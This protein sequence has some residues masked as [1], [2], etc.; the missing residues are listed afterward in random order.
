MR[1]LKTRLFLALWL[2][3]SS[4][5]TV[6]MYVTQNRLGADI[7][8]AT[9]AADQFLYGALWLIFTPLILWIAK[10]IPFRKKGWP[11]A[12]GL[13]FLLGII[14]AVAQAWLYMFILSLYGFLASGAPLAFDTLFTRLATFFDYGIHLYWLVVVLDYVYEYYFIARRHELD[15]AKLE[16]QLAGAHLR[17]LTMQVRPHFLFN[18]LNSI[19]VLIRSEPDTAR[20]MVGHLA[21]L[22]RYTL[23]VTGQSEIT[24]RKEVEFLQNY[25]EIEKTRFRDRLSIELRVPEETL[26]AM[27]PAMILQPLVENSVKHGVSKVGGAGMIEISAGRVNGEL[28]LAVTNTGSGS[29]WKTAPEGVGLSN[30]RSRLKHLYGENQEFRL[31]G[32]GGNGVTAEIILPFHTGEEAE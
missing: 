6:Q 4:Y 1:T 26:D 31:M 20:R 27:V 17:A 10:K 16:A 5:M 12:F 15:M 19:S 30:T 29:E 24:L 21:S 11:L 3:Y 25:L 23:S 13:H 28:R 2:V 32:N 22:L 14:L 18:T 7:S 8:W 9:A